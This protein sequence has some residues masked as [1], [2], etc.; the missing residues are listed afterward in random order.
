MP[1]SRIVDIARN[2]EPLRDIAASVKAGK[3]RLW[4]SGLLGSSKS[5][6]AAVLAR[7]LP[8]V[9]VVIAPT[10]SD[11]EHAYDDLTTFLGE[12][13]VQMF[14]E[15]ETLP[16]ERRSPL[17]TITESQTPDALAPRGWRVASS[18]LR[19]RRPSCRRPCR[20]A[21]WPRRR[22]RSPRG[23][24]STSGRSRAHSSTCGYKRVRLVEE[25]GDFSVRGGIVDLLPFGYDDPLRVELDG[26]RIESIRQFDVY[27]QRSIRELDEVSVLPRREV[28]LRGEG[29]AEI[30]SRLRE[31]HPADSEDRDHLLNGLETRFYFDG[32]EQYLPAINKDTETLVDYLPAEAGVF[33][34]R[35]D[36]VWDRAEQLSLE[37]AKI[38]HETERAGAALRARIAS[39]SVRPADGESRQEADRRLRPRRQTRYSRATSAGRSMRSCRSRSAPTSS[40]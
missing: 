25:S 14:S 30:A 20:G 29:S 15:W 9:W 13:N 11:A 28:V 22:T 7:E 32:V 24:R 37:A 18:S 36:E 27:N 21:C 10:F 3:R 16:Y 31:L 6:L 17:A 2:A 38:Y 8:R 23:R 1:G 35:S 34:V 33:V 19:R 12:D 26:D 5:L 40:F 39:R 4:V